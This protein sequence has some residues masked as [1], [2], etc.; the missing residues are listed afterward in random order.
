M[1][2]QISVIL[3]MELYEGMSYPTIRFHYFIELNEPNSRLSLC[4]S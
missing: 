4:H 1:D 2:K 3:L